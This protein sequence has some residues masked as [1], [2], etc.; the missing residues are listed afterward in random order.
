M[1]FATDIPDEG[2]TIMGNKRVV[3]GTI[4]QGNGD[5]GGAIATDLSEIYGFTCSIHC[6]TLS[7]SGGTVTITTAD[8]LGAQA[9]YF[10]AIGF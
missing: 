8:P 9:G 5:T 1:A 3:M 7:V 2:R 10:S 6:T 4:T